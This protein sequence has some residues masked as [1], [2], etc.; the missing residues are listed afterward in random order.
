MHHISQSGRVP[1]DRRLSGG[2]EIRLYR[3][4]WQPHMPGAAGEHDGLG[5]AV[6][7]AGGPC[8]MM[9]A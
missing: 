8:R 5:I 9:S 2:F 6:A 7:L 4:R 3:A 1:P